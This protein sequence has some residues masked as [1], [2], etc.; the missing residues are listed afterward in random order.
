MMTGG[1][2]KYWDCCVRNSRPISRDVTKSTKRG[3]GGLLVAG[4]T[5]FTAWLGLN[6]YNSNCRQGNNAMQTLTI[7][8]TYHDYIKRKYTKTYY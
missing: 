5:W 6:P 1:V 8:E 3:Y 4:L 7:K 2:S